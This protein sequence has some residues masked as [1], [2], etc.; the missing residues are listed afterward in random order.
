MQCSRLFPALLIVA[1]SLGIACSGDAASDT[2]PGPPVTRPPSEGAPR[3]LQLGLGAQPVEAT[4]TELIRTIAGTARNAEVVSIARVPPWEEFLDDGEVSDGTNALMALERGLVRQYGLSLL[5]AIDPTDGAAQRERIAGLP[6][7]TEA[8]GGFL[9]EDVQ[10]ALVDFAVY[11]ATNYE[12]ASLVIGVE[13]NML[14]ARSPAQFEGF[15]AAY[16]RAYDAV[17]SIRPGIRVFPTFQLED[18]LGIHTRQHAPQWEAIDAFGERIDA[19]AFSTYPYLSPAIA[20]VEEIPEDYYR[21]LRTRFAGEILISEAGYASTGVEGHSWVGSEEEQERY[22]QRLL[23]EAERHG[24]ST[25]VWVA[26][27][28]PAE[29][30]RGAA[31]VLNGTGLQLSDGTDKRAWAVWWT[32]ARRPLP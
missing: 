3:Q 20:Q 31:A 32:W 15:L 2:T 9:R 6:A 18:L 29:P 8:A 27:R 13:I 5:F 21:Q 1:V 25:V 14:R 12:P 4:R 30:R 22:L 23:E 26:E 16:V 28:D 10:E 7:G 24:F 11:V 19:F 17:K